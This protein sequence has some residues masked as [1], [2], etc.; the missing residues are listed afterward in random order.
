MTQL[1][2]IVR[3]AD[4]FQH[5][6][7]FVS[8]AFRRSRIG[9]VDRHID[10]DGAGAFGDPG[11]RQ[12]CNVGTLGLPTVRRAHGRRT[13]RWSG[14]PPESRSDAAA[15][16]LRAQRTQAL[17]RCRWFRCRPPAQPKGQTARRRA[18]EPGSD[19]A[20]SRLSS[21]FP[22]HVVSVDDEAEIGLIASDLFDP[23]R[24][25][26]NAIDLREQRRLCIGSGRK[27]VIRP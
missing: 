27:T 17:Q 6:P 10:D 15:D 2:S 3:Y 20:K 5:G 11:P 1:D 23:R 13:E 21:C 16:N 19:R 8:C 24:N 26:V 7:R 22:R 25:A 18:A 9:R 14:R 4:R 12:S